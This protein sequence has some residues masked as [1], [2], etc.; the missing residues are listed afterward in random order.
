MVNIV[1]MI[2][3]FQIDIGDHFEHW[4]EFQKGMIKSV[5][6]NLA[7]SDEKYK[8]I[9]VYSFEDWMKRAA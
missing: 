9:K 4:R 8:A 2:H 1:I 7:R 6:R 3:V 5:L